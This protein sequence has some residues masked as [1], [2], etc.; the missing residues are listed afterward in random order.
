MAASLFVNLIKRRSRIQ[1]IN[2]GN[3]Q[4]ESHKCLEYT[5]E[6]ANGHKNLNS[7]EKKNIP[8]SSK[9]FWDTH[10]IDLISSFVFLNV[11]MVGLF[12]C[13]VLICKGGAICRKVS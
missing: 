11:V 12:F 10:S 1:L 13:D 4:I 8:Q 2:F 6:I 9:N 7:N 5:I 3:C